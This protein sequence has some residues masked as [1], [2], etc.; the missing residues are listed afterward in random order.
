MIYDRN[1]EKMNVLSGWFVMTT[2]IMSTPGILI[3][4]WLKKWFSR[5]KKKHLPLGDPELF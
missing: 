3:I 1:G 2:K 4:G 5:I